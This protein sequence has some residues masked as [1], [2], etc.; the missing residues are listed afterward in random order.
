MTSLETILAS[1]RALNQLEWEELRR[2]LDREAMFRREEQ[3]KRTQ[4][5]NAV[6]GKYA[7]VPTSVDSFLERKHDDTLLEDR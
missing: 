7:H 3:A 2:T 5:V 6:F 1:V 4:V